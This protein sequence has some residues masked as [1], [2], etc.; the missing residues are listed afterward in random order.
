MSRARLTPLLLVGLIGLAACGAPRAGLTVSPSTPEP[1]AKQLVQMPAADRE[2]ESALAQALFEL[3]PD[4][5]PPLVAMVDSPQADDDAAARFA[6]ESVTRWVS[7]PGRENNRELWAA[8]LAAEIDRGG[9]VVSRRFVL[10]Q[11]ETAGGAGQVGSVAALLADPELHVAAA[12]TLVAIGSNDAAT[13]IVTALGAANDEPSLALLTAAGTL[14]AAD[15]R[16]ELTAALT[17]P[18]PAIRL[19][20]AGALA[21]IAHPRSGADLIDLLLR[22]APAERAA[23]GAITLRYAATSDDPAHG[24]ATVRSVLVV[25]DRSGDDTLVLAAM[26]TLAGIDQDLAAD[27]LATRDPDDSRVAAELARLARRLDARAAAIERSAT[28]ADEGFVALFNGED[29]AGW[30]GATDGYFVDGDAIV[31]DPAT[32]GNLYTES[33][34]ADF[35]LRFEFRLTPGANNGLGIRAP[36]EGDAAYVGMELQVLDDGALVYAN[37]QPYQYHGSVYGV[38]AAERGHQRPV[39][40]WNEQ[41]VVAHGR[42]IQVTLNGAVIVDVDLDEASTPAT[43]DGREHPGLARASGH[44]GFLGHGH[45]VEY[46]SIRIRELVAGTAVV[47]TPQEAAW[48]PGSAL[49]YTGRVDGNSEIVLLDRGEGTNLSAD[50]DQDHMAT[51]A[52]DGSRLA[53]QTTRDGN[54]E[55]YLMNADGSMPQNLTRHAAQDLLPR[56]SPDGGSIVFFSDRAIPDHPANQLPGHLFVMRADGSDVRQLTAAALTSTF[57]GSWSPDSNNVLFARDY[58]GD[59]DLTVVDVMTGVE[60]RLPGTDLA[61]YGGAYSPDGRQ[62]AFHAAA[63]DG[64]SRLVVMA[65]DGTQRRE[66]TTGGQHYGPVWSPDGT[67]LMFTGAPLG[68]T[69]FDVLYV[70]ATGGEIHTAV[71]TEADERNGTWRPR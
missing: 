42:H 21:A 18:D 52:P 65:A 9:S 45:R 51:W 38:A 57:A 64:E 70:A 71:A 53:F 59:I 62:I 34:F 48:D 25:A 32:G 8:Q 60:R 56:F 2:H 66:V 12:R 41:E 40:Q 4:A 3:E 7:S 37:L 6:I 61:E 35:V 47:A 58:D 67:W 33:E 44:I 30:V 5:L 39:G 14:G 23:L 11:L 36:L 63:P 16:A 55:I 17:S 31:S 50:P 20:A 13:A 46:R 29:L 19:A 15:A 43:V 28:E 49:V 24:A 54:R 22:A 26:N 10:G 69:Q 1:L 68:A 27:E